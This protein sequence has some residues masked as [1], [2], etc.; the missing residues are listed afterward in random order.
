MKGLRSSGASV[1]SAVSFWLGNPT[2]NPAV[3]VFLIFTLGWK[4]AVLRLALGLLLVFGAA[5]LAT[6]ITSG[7]SAIN[8]WEVERAASQS[9]QQGNLLVRWLRSLFRLTISLVPAYIV[10]V[11]LLGALRAF[12][13]PAAGPEIGND[14]LVLVGIAIAGMV[15]VIPTAGEIPIIQT[16]IAYGI[17]SG[18]AGVLLLTLAPISLP[19]LAMMSRSFPKRVLVVTAGLTILI[20]I[21]SG[22]LALSLL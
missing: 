13:F 7:A 3:L 6:R 20:G 17:G 4:W 10:I 16:M 9:T 14:F 21:V 12:L 8:G 1:G 19:S 18:P 11:M 15:F 5:A 22:L 2:L